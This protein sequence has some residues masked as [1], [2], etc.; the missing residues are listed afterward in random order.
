MTEKTESNVAEIINQGALEDFILGKGEFDSY[1]PEE[2]YA[3][4]RCLEEYYNNL[5]PQDQHKIF[6]TNTILSLYER[7]KGDKPLS[8]I[9]KILFEL[10]WNY[11]LRIL[12]KKE[13]EKRCALSLSWALNLKEI[14]P[15]IISTIESGEYF[16]LL[17]DTQKDVLIAAINLEIDQVREFIVQEK[18]RRNELF[19]F[20][21]WTY[22]LEKELVTKH[23]LW[24]V[25]SIEKCF[26]KAGQQERELLA[27]QIEQLSQHKHAKVA[28]NFII[29]MFTLYLE[30]EDVDKKF[31]E[32][33]EAYIRH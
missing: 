5:S 28:E 8:A 10:S 16:H 14:I 17:D 29:R 33:L 27:V 18:A 11:R 23:D 4:W 26:E 25:A 9:Q 12:N 7:D 30:K 15:Q 1:R 32:I 13:Y 24:R 6:I 19:D 31:A 3:R 2:D 22:H 21:L 20:L